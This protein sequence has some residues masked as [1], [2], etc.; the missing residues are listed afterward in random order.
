MSQYVYQRYRRALAQALA[1][2]HRTSAAEV[3]PGL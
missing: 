1:A 2:A 3:D